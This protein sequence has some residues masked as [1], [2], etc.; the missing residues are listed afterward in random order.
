MLSSWFIWAWFPPVK[1]LCTWH[2]LLY[3]CLLR[4]KFRGVWN[5][6]Q[7]FSLSYVCWC[8]NLAGF[9]KFAV[10]RSQLQRPPVCLSHTY[11]PC[12][13]D[14]DSHDS[15][16]CENVKC[17]WKDGNVSKWDLFW[18]LICQLPDR[19]WD[20]KMLDFTYRSVS[21]MRQSIST[22]YICAMEGENHLTC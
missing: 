19:W 20:L 5:S 14:R 18:L 16:Y 15:G 8:L 4:S 9:V 12:P 7:R 17:V 1:H 10:G 21:D 6:W 2:G 11:S 22:L 13:A 3:S